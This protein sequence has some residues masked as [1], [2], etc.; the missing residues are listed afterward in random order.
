VKSWL[1]AT[2]FAVAACA[3]SAPPAPAT[4]GVPV[5]V[6]KNVRLF[7]GDD[8]VGRT[9]VEIRGDIIVKVAPVIEAPAGAIVID[10]YG[11]T[12]LPG[13]IDAHVHLWDE[14]QL[15]AAAVFG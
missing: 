6:F 7:T 12:L 1:V 10:G 11:K 15:Q 5:T 14:E 8:T 3:R 9:S 4:G 13:L 2:L